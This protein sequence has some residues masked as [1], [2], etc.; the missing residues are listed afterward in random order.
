MDKQ[1]KISESEVVIINCDDDNTQLVPKKKMK[2]GKR[3]KKRKVQIDSTDNKRLIIT[4]KVKKQKFQCIINLTNICKHKHKSKVTLDSF[5]NKKNKKECEDLRSD[6][7]LE[8]VP[9]RCM[10]KGCQSAK[11]SNCRIRQSK[12]R[13]A[14]KVSHILFIYPEYWSY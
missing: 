7:I 3:Q 1:L 5:L 2:N 14:K 12:K 11:T 4:Q 8:R 9:P 6:P 10:R 13:N